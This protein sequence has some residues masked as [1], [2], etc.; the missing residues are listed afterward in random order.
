MVN[1]CSAFNCSSASDVKNELI[2]HEF[3]LYGSERLKKW[4][5]AVRRTNFKPSCNSFLC[6]LHFVKNDY[7]EAVVSGK[8]VLKKCAVPTIF[9][10]PD[11]LMPK[12]KERRILQ[13]SV[14]IQDEIEP[15][16][17]S[18]NASDG[19]KSMFVD[20]G[21]QTKLTGEELDKTIKDL[22]REKKIL[23]QK[24]LRRNNR[25]NVRMKI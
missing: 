16:Q 20:V 6:S 14:E 25:E 2:F 7:N 10:F 15:V 22:R 17:S 5:H 9:E 19:T 8:L 23:Q 3:P 13:R 24:L 21:V 4:I 12:V 11:H 1:F 18:A